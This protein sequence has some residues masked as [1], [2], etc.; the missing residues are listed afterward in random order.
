MIDLEPF[1]HEAVLRS[2]HVVVI[3]LRKARMQP[4]AGLA[5][6]AVTDTVGKDDVVTARIEELPAAKQHVGE[7]RRE[8]LPA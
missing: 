2:H 8:E 5:R 3:V 7:L 6:P 4:V 1:G